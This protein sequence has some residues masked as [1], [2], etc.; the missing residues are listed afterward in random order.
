[1]NRLIAIGIDSYDDPLIPDLNNFTG[2]KQGDRSYSV[3]DWNK[4]NQNKPVQK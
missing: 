4:V 3:A 2:V 1:M